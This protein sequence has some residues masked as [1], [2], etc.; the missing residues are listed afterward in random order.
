MRVAK[1]VSNEINFYLIGGYP[2]IKL[3]GQNCLEIKLFFIYL[4]GGQDYEN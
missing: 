3:T 4:I 1:N 2:I